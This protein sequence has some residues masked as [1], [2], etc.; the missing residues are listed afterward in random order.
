VRQMMGSSAIDEL[1]GL[2]DTMKGLPGSE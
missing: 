2:T 1:P